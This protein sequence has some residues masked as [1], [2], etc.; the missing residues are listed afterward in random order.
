MHA[1]CMLTYVRCISDKQMLVSP[2]LLFLLDQPS[3]FSS[4]SPKK[5]TRTKTQLPSP[6]TSFSTHLLALTPPLFLQKMLVHGARWFF[7]QTWWI[8][9]TH[10]SLHPS[11]NYHQRNKL[12]KIK[13]NLVA[14][15]ERAQ[16]IHQ[17]N[18]YL[19]ENT[20]IFPC[21]TANIGQGL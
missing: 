7:S 12:G 18:K 5:W 15:F 4:I 8:L 14:L 1:K 6:C 3:L 11:P 20:K 17:Y 10:H 2:A 21:C 9:K 16:I 19:S 13:L